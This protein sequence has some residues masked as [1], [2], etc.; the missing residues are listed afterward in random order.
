MTPGAQSSA[1]FQPGDAAYMSRD[2]VSLYADVAWDPNKDITIGAAARFEHYDD[3]SGNTLIWK[4]NGLYAETDWIADRAAANT[5]FPAPA[6][7]QQI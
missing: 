2:N 7:G 6:V 1:G 4:V 5:G 3:G